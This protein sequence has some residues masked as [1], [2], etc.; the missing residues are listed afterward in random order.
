LQVYHATCRAEALGSATT[1]AARLRTSGDASRAAT[2][3][4]PASVTVK[5]EPETPPTSL[6]GTKRKAAPDAS[7][8]PEDGGSPPPSKKAHA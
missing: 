6:A 3:D 1:L 4:T 5:A 8:K 7:V 2:P